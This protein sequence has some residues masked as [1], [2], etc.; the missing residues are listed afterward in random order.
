M[1]QININ[2]KVRVKLTPHGRELVRAQWERTFSFLPQ[3]PPYRAPTED[4]AGW[5]TWQLWE[6]MSIFGPYIYHGGQLPF[7]T[8]IRLSGDEAEQ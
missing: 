2:D 4:F 8:T 7:E 5:S 3:P 6:L 1:N